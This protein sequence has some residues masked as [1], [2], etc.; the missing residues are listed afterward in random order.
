MQKSIKGVKKIAVLTGGG[1]CPGLNAVIRAIW[2]SS[3]KLGWE[4]YGVKNGFDGLVKPESVFLLDSSKT[5]GIL[6]RGGTIIGTTNVADPFSYRRLRAGVPEVVDMSDVVVDRVKYYNFSG[7]IAIG[8]DGTLGIANKMFKK[9]V[10]IVG[11]PKT[12]DNDLSATETTFGFDTALQTATEAIDRLHTT[13]ESHQ[14]VMILEVM[15]RDAGWIA[16]HAGVAGGADIILIPEIPFD[17][18]KVIDTVQNR[19]VYGSDF[20]VIV[21]AEGAKPGDGEVRYK[22]IKEEGF[23]VK[24]L[25]GIGNYVGEKMRQ[26][27]SAEVRVTILGHIQRGG[28]PTAFDRILGTRYGAA[29]VELIEKKRYG[30]MVSY[31]SGKIKSVTLDAAVAENKQVDPNSDF[32]KTAKAMGISFGD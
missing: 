5:R 18:S 25:G 24:R 15:G 14:R 29:A 11:V 8:G 16:L 30:R 1:D 9:G 31:S 6:H 32:V 20:S 4:V 23:T 12:I 21:V 7:L 22:E 26:M 10:P 13:A 17:I 27:S 19:Y 28:S 3:N 2:K